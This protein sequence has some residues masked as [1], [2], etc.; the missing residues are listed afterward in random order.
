MA[1]KHAWLVLVGVAAGAGWHGVQAADAAG[2]PAL[3]VAPPAAQWVQRSLD[4]T[5]SGFT[6]KFSCDGLRDTVRDVLL[7][8]GARKQDLDVQSHGCIKLEGPETFPGVAAHFSVLV[9]VT[10]DDIGKVGRA[11]ANPTQWK[12]VDLVRLTQD[13][14]DS[15]PCELLEQ[16]K[17]KAL[18][19]FTNR[20][21][22]F[23]SSCYPHA[24]TPGEIKFTV[25]VLQ[26][27]SAGA[28]A[29]AAPPPAA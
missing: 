4:Y 6:D 17:G 13:G 16:L 18:P 19:L 23:R 26:P 24:I 7:A 14:R 28:A 20:N 22:K 8:L 10:P 1:M 11:T 3:S 27:A 25:D 15:A 9:P 5:Y 12:T 21:L 29:G 2:V